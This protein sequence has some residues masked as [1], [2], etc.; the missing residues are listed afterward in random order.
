M[1]VSLNLLS[2]NHFS[3]VAIFEDIEVR[4]ILLCLL[5]SLNNSNKR[6]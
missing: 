5:S 4:L 6:T 1:V 3:T 2:D